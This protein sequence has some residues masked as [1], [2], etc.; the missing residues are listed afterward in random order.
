MV[1][2]ELAR[3]RHSGEI[4]WLRPDCKAQIIIKYSEQSCGRLVPLHIDTVLVS[5]QHEPHLAKEEISSTILEKVIKK[6]C[7]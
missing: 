7:P 6:V 3:A 2:E 1:C 5:V 4:P